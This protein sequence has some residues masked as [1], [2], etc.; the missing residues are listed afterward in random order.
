MRGNFE[1]L[2]SAVLHL[3]Q[4]KEIWFVVKLADR[5]G[6]IVDLSLNV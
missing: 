4:S 1:V 3:N 5:I 2:D 6:L